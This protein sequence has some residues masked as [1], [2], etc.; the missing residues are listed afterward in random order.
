MAPSPNGNAS[1]TQPTDFIGSG[2]AFPLRVNARGGLALARREQDV[3]ESIRIILSTPVGERR[4]RPRFGCGVHDLTF[5]TNDPATHGLIRYH[6]LQALALWEP[7]IE[8]RED[9]VRVRTDPDEPS[10]VLVEIDYAIRATNQRRNLVYPFYLI[11][12]EPE[13]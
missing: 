7:R 1:S 4:M 8:L 11:P 3:D 13:R 10:R 6:V 5:A 12:G 2:W 9:G